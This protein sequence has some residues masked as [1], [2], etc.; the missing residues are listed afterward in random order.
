MGKSRF[1][2]WLQFKNLQFKEKKERKKNWKK[3]NFSKNLM[4]EV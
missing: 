3:A 2:L 4:A 1:D